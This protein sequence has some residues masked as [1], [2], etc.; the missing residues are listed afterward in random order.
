MTCIPFKIQKRDPDT[1]EWTDALC[2]HATQVNRG[3]ARENFN[4]AAEQ[5]HPRLTFS[6]RWCMALEDLMYNTQDTRIVY[7]GH[8]FNIVNY[9]DYMEQHS[10]VKIEAEAY[11]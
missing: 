4:A 10:I 7:R 5:Y 11:A 8:F 2:L 6:V 1:E 9:D 3:S